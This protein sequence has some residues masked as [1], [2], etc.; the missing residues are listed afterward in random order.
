MGK[1]T[2][3]RLISV[4]L[5]G[6]LFVSE[7]QAQQI[8]QPPPNPKPAGWDRLCIY[9]DD[10]T[11]DPEPSKYRFAYER[12]LYEAAGAQRSDAPEVRSNEMSHLWTNHLLGYTCSSISFD[13]GRGNFAKFAVANHF[14]HFIYW[15]TRG[16][17][18][19]PAALNAIDCSDGRTL[20]DYVRDHLRKERASDGVFRGKLESYER[21]LVAAGASG[22]AELPTDQCY[23]SDPLFAGSPN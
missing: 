18:L 8:E 22:A 15:M 23:G 17:R 10:W 19:R 3:L 5:A 13:I 7:V 14:D 4:C 9:V 16:W 1:A 20:L 6:V 21:L 2:N 11:T 12:V